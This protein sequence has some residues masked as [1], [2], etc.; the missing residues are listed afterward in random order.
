MVA[1]AQYDKMTA[2]E[3]WMKQDEKERQ[4]VAITAQLEQIEWKNTQI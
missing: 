3:T 2:Q 4:L 1:K